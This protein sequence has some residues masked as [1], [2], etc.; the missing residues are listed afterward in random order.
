MFF[1][2][3]FIDFLKNYKLTAVDC[4]II[5]VTINTVIINISRV[6]ALSNRQVT[7]TSTVNIIPFHPKIV[8]TIT[9]SAQ[10]CVSLETTTDTPD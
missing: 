9:I 1:L 10:K 6:G 2:L 3:K 8:S 7:A 5:T 4:S